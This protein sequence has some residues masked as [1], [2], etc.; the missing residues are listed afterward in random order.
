M[1]N[2]RRLLWTGTLALVL[3]AG[4]GKKKEA[5]SSAATAPQAAEPAVAA[6]VQSVAEKEAPYQVRDLQLSVDA[7]V[8]IYKRKPGSLEQMIREGFLASLP[9]APTG[10]RFVLDPATARVGLEP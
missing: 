9:P 8:K 2:S 6:Q 1:R 10:K 3:A 5:S 4:C 7:Y